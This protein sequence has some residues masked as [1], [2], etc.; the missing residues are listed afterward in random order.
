MPVEPWTL[1][2][3]RIYH[4]DKK[5]NMHNIPEDFSNT[6][7]RWEEKVVDVYLS[8]R[9]E[10]EQGLNHP[11]HLPDIT[12]SLDLDIQ[13]TVICI[14]MTRSEEKHINWILNVTGMLVWYMA[15]LLEGFVSWNSNFVEVIPYRDITQ[16]L[17]QKEKRSMKQF[18]HYVFDLLL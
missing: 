2:V 1:R 3:R 18:G 5:C 6:V 11:N 14:Q 10:G 16:H 17:T 4:K 12:Q 15:W 13:D 9:E 7:C 8:F